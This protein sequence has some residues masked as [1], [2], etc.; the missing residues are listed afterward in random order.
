MHSAA[1]VGICRFII[2]L[3]IATRCGAL[4]YHYIGGMCVRGCVCFYG[5]RVFD[6]GY[7]D[8]VTHIESNKLKDEKL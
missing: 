7:I 4:W 6:R 1:G 2:L 5:S 8:G 3:G